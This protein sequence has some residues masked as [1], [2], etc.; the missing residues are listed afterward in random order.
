MIN[1]CIMASFHAFKQLDYEGGAQ[2]LLNAPT[3]VNHNH[4]SNHE[5]IP[6]ASPRFEVWLR[7]DLLNR[8]GERRPALLVG[9]AE[10]CLMARL[11]LN[12]STVESIIPVAFTFTS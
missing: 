4:R 10:Y 9:T 11:D 1:V 8:K 6:H 2:K 12:S 7:K 3:R 5:A